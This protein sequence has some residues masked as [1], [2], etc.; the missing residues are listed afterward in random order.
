V[1]RVETDLRAALHRR[2]GRVHASPRLLAADYH[3]RTRHVWPFAVGGG[4]AA[5]AGAIVAALALIGG[6]SDAFAQWTAQ[7]TTPTQHQL[8][9]ANAYCAVNVPTPGLPLKLVDARGP[10]MVVVYSD[11]SSN[12]F[13]TVG[14]SFSNASGWSTSPPVTVP[15]GKLF[16]WE[17][18]TT[19]GSGH[20]Y[21]FLIARAGADVSAAGLTLD[22]GSRVGATVESG[23]AVAWW[24][25][26]Q[27]IVKA[28]LTTASGMRTQTFRS[29]RCGLHNCDGGP[30]GRSGRGGSGV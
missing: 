25:G 18:H 14:P 19:T 22:D 30:H 15:N 7:P 13:C 9:A 23:W 16:L 26:R 27:Q 4:L 6:A 24:P 3:P 5:A 28:Q 11:G 8:A 17:Q 12:D 20:A 29:S 10:F 1:T 2:A 21:T